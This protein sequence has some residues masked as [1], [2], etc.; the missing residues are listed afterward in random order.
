[1]QQSIESTNMSPWM[2]EI[3]N[4]GCQPLQPAASSMYVLKLEGSSLVV[5]ILAHLGNLKVPFG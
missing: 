4:A 1:M 5:S 2:A 3:S